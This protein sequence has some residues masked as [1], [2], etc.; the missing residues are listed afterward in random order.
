MTKIIEKSTLFSKT[1]KNA[2]TKKKSEKCVLNSYVF[3]PRALMITDFDVKAGIA[4]SL[5][6]IRIKFHLYIYQYFSSSILP[7][8]SIQFQ[9][10]IHSQHHQTVVFERKKQL[11]PYNSHDMSH[12]ILPF[13]FPALCRLVKILSKI[14]IKSC[15]TFSNVINV[16]FLWLSNVPHPKIQCLSVS[17]VKRPMHENVKLSLQI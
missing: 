5:V 7:V 16:Y 10:S 3:F 11:N 14:K 6:S 4:R 8:L 13:D 9:S 2:C 17:I 1:T 12:H 15:Y